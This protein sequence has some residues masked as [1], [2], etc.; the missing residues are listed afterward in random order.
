MKLQWLICIEFVSL[1]SRKYHSIPTQKKEL[2]EPVSFQWKESENYEYAK[3]GYNI[4][5]ERD[6]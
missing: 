5:T 3:N 2:M 4:G 1:P 6:G